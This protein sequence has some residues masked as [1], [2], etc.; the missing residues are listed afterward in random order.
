M[1][2]ATDVYGL[3]A[4]LYE[5]LTGRP[6]FQGDNFGDILEKVREEKPVPPRTVNR[7][8]NRDLEK[9][10]LN[11]LDKDPKQRYASADALADDLERWL[12]HRP[13]H[14]RRYAPGERLRL[15][16]RRRPAVATLVMLLVV[17]LVS[18]VGAVSWLA[19]HNY[20]LADNLGKEL[21]RGNIKLAHRDILDGR[22]NLASEILDHCPDPLRNWEWHY[23]RRLC[24]LERKVLRGHEAPITCIRYRPDGKVLAT[25]SRDGTLR[26]WNAQ[27][28]RQLWRRASGSPFVHGLCFSGSGR[29]LFSASEEQLLTAWDA[30]SGRPV[31]SVRGGG[32]RVAASRSGNRLATLCSNLLPRGPRPPRGGGGRG[33]FEVKVWD[34]VERGG[35][36]SLRSRLRLPLGKSRLLDVALSPDGRYLAV[37]GWNKLIRL[38]EILPDRAALVTS[39]LAAAPLAGTGPWPAVGQALAA[40]PLLDG[41]TSPARALEPFRRDQQGDVTHVRALCFSSDGKYLAAGSSLPSLWEVPSGRFVRSFTGTGDRICLT[42]SFSE[43]GQRLAATFGD[44]MVRVWATSDGGAVMTPPRQPQTVWGATF[45]PADNHHLAVIR[46][47]EAAIENVNPK[48]I[49]TSIVLTGEDGHEKPNVRA[50]AF[51]PDGK[52]LA[53]RAEGA[54]VL[55]DVEGRHRLRRIQPGS[56][57]RGSLVFSPNGRFLISGGKAWAVDSGAEVAPA[58]AS[59]PATAALLLAFSGDGRR[60]AT[61][62]GSGQV[63]L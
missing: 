6:P 26:L 20:R 37:C 48:S 12:G 22:L 31:L 28:G 36:V 52:L 10:C 34:V 1:T 25:A 40:G 17:S 19:W 43:D 14:I 35:R 7:E 18:G 41:L 54:I 51:H 9:V 61:S 30:K 59:L 63:R 5:L 21:Y 24:R 3:G 58:A 50:V 33:D 32:S 62:D 56:D 27:T 8:V 29:L 23:L 57:P 38:W 16:V 44:R 60:L 55:W 42:V 4:V 2:T 15:W 53:S 46:G 49:R 47:V 13:I 39:V 45:S 11:C